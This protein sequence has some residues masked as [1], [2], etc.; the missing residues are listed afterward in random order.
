MLI[1]RP[2]ID[3]VELRLPVHDPATLFMVEMGPLR[4][5]FAVD[6]SDAYSAFKYLHNYTNNVTYLLKRVI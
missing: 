4:M 2:R 1:Q 5:H 3:D 6:A